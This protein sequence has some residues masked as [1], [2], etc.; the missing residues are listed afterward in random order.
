MQK[1][2]NNE[3]RWN[4]ADVFIWYTPVTGINH[5]LY[6]KL[7]API[8]DFVFSPTVGERRLMCAASGSTHSWS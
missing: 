2:Q 4:S 8:D 5:I 6:I 7:K 3:K 1:H